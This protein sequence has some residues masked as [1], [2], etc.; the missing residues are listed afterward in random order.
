MNARR[1]NFWTAVITA[2]ICA[3]LLIGIAVLSAQTSSDFITQR[4]STFF[5]DHTGSRA[6]LLVLQR[7][8]P[9][10][11]Q[12]RRPFSELP[13]NSKTS[14]PT[15]IVLGPGEPLG[16][17]EAAVL[18]RWITSGG[19]LILAANKEWK[20][21]KPKPTEKEEDQYFTQGY[22]ERHHLKPV[23]TKAGDDA[24][25]ATITTPMGEG[26]ILLVSDPYAF[27]ND[28]MRNTDDAVW[29]AARISEWSGDTSSIFIDEYHHGFGD[30]RGFTELLVLFFLHSW[31]GIA[32]MQLA[33]AGLVYMLG[34]KRRF[35]RP[36][37]ELPVERTSP[38]EAVEALGGLFEAAQARVLS[39]RTIHQHLNVQL[40]TMFGYPVDLANNATRDRISQRSSLDR[41]A[42]DSYAE[43]VQRALTGQT[44]SDIDVLQIARDATTISRSFS[45]G[46]SRKR[47]AL[48]G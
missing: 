27:S 38:I 12:W 22:L 28:A 15:M 16:E 2:G 3:L 6:I 44:I 29:L 43:T 8:A 47:P 24:V 36:I 30:R 20:I 35:G 17:T 41:A 37:E 33:L 7:L 32:G 23:V 39:V 18:D 5:T 25:A 14:H 31:W 48:A 1:T 11:D 4:P 46:S 42:L 34:C 10:T 19:Q 45:H 21:R 9:S 40:T 26:R 13:V